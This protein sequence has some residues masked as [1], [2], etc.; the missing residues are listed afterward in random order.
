LVCSGGFCRNPNCTGNTNCVCST[1][2]PTPTPTGTLGP[3]PTPTAPAL[4]SSGTDW[5]S[6]LG[7]IVGAA[8]IIG[9][10]VLAL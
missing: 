10:L 9:S 8:T 3:T 6:M 2:T 5:P 4:P 7:I 1:A